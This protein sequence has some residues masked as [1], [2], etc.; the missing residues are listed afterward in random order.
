VLVD[1]PDVIARAGT[2]L[3][4]AGVSDRIETAA[5]E[6]FGAISAEADVYLLKDVLHD[7]DDEHCRKILSTVAAAMPSGSR[8]VLIELL[9][10]PNT[11]NPLAPW[12]D[13]PMLTQSDG[14]RRRSAAELDALLADAGLRPTHR[15]PRAA[16]RPRRSGQTLGVAQKSGPRD[17]IS[18]SNLGVFNVKL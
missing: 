17:R 1:S 5:G 10:A 16:T 9:Q 8:V 14:G 7:W 15:A 13:L 12:S 6:M 18:A 4:A 11:P 3:T 2:F